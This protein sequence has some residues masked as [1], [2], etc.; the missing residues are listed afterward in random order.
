MVDWDPDAIDP[1]WRKHMVV[2]DDEAQEL[3]GYD[4]A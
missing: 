2:D 4:V 3:S 1:E